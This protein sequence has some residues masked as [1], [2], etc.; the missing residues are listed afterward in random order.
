MARRQFWRI[1][2][3]LLGVFFICMWNGE[4]SAQNLSRCDVFASDI[5]P[6]VEPFPFLPPSKNHSLQTDNAASFGGSMFVQKRKGQN[7]RPENSAQAFPSKPTG[8]DGSLDKAHMK[9]PD[10]STKGNTPDTVQHKIDSGPRTRA[11]A[12]RRRA[13]KE[14]SLVTVDLLGQ[15]G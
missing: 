1:S 14:S 4:H 12:G 11:T 3:A 13:T 5:P 6:R 2:G 7:C 15:E 8:S 9:P 10:P